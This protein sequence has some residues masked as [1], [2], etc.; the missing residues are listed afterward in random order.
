[1][2]QVSLARPR[3]WTSTSNVERTPSRPFGC[4]DEAIV[5]TGGGCEKSDWALAGWAVIYMRSPQT[6]LQDHH[7]LSDFTLS[8]GRRTDTL[9]KIK[10]PNTSSTAPSGVL[11]TQLPLRNDASLFFPFAELR[12]R[13][14]KRTDANSIPVL[15][16]HVVDVPS[17]DSPKHFRCVE[18][19][20]IHMDIGLMSWF[21][22]SG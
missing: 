2:P 13:L 5:E 17:P 7:A 8:I 18:C 6:T 12:R 16:Y 4:W 14:D 9:D 3:A 21:G 19:S 15:L 22:L 11:P 20:R 1:M 10:Q